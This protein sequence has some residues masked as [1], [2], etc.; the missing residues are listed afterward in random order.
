MPAQE[1][2]KTPGDPK[3]ILFILLM[4]LLMRRMRKGEGR[5]RVRLGDS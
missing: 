1:A 2:K 3:F 4:L 5:K